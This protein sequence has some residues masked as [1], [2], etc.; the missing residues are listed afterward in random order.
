MGATSNVSRCADARGLGVPQDDREAIHWFRTAAAQGVATASYNLGVMY[1][2][3]NRSPEDREYGQA[4]H[5]Y[6]V[7]AAQGHA[8]AEYNLGIMLRKDRCEALRRFREAAE[9]GLADAQYNLGVMYAC[10]DGA[11]KDLT[12]AY[13]WLNLAAAQGFEE[14]ASFRD[15]LESSMPQAKIVEAQHLSR[16]L[17]RQPK[18]SRSPQV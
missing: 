7:A 16:R 12:Q 1:S 17:A 3:C 11:E 14:A 9:H 6:A 4:M 5:F 18:A 8:E 2:N 13:A 15:C 10:G